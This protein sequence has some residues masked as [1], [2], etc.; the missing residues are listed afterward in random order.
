[1]QQLRAV[2]EN[3]HKVVNFLHRKL[4]AAVMKFVT[5][6]LQGGFVNKQHFMVTRHGE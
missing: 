3:V 4:L 6:L 2:M 5:D 1:M